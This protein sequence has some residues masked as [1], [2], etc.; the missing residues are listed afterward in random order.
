MADATT[1]RR[2]PSRSGVWVWTRVPVTPQHAVQIE[3]PGYGALS[4]G[5]S[6]PAQL[7]FAEPTLDDTTNLMVAAGVV[8]ISSA[9]VKTVAQSFDV[10][11]TTCQDTLL[12]SLAALS[13]RLNL[14]IPRSTAAATW[15]H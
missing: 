5:G 12:P 14:A 1:R 11:D 4:V 10:I 6:Q 8:N 15:I 3:K 7:G 2:H 13:D 9:A